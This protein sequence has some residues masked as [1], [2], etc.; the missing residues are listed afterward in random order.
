[1]PIKLLSNEPRLYLKSLLKKNFL[2]TRLERGI[3]K[4][5]GNQIEASK[6]SLVFDSTDRTAMTIIVH[7]QVS[8]RWRLETLLPE[9]SLPGRS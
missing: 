2:I 8:L 1:M 5:P 7:L 4:E 3:S 6:T 9:E